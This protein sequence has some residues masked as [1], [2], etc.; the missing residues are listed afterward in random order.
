M[1]GFYSTIDNNGRCDSYLASTIETNFGTPKRF[2]RSEYGER[3]ATHNSRHEVISTSRD[4]N[5]GS[6]K[7]TPLANGGVKLKY[8][9]IFYMQNIVKGEYRDRKFR[10]T[11]EVDINGDGQ[12]TKYK[13]STKTLEDW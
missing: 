12:I 11:T 7:A 4:Y 2:S 9:Q 10:L 6:L 3:M 8:N 1:E 5:W 13:E